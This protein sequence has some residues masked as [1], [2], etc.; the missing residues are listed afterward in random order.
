M[1]KTDKEAKSETVV[2][3]PQVIYLIFLVFFSLK[4]LEK[5]SITLQWYA[6]NY[7]LKL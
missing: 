4:F 7:D 5:R 2:G 1:W 3:P 6:T